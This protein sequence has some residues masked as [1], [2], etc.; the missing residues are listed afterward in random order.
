MWGML[1]SGRWAHGL[2]VLVAIAPAAE[3]Q[4]CSALVPGDVI[5]NEILFDR[6]NPS[7][8]YVELYNRSACPVDL[9]R[10]TLSDSR[11]THE[12]ISEIELLLEP[13]GFTVLASDAAGFEMV[14][15]DVSVVVPGRWPALN[16]G[17]DA[18]VLSDG[19]AVLDS[20]RY[21]GSWGT[22]GR[23]L[24]R[25]APSASATSAASWGPS[26]DPAGGTPG[27][28]NSLFVKDEEPPRLIFAEQ[29]AERE[30][31][32]RFSEP[33]DLARLAATQFRAGAQSPDHLEP[34]LSADEIRLGFASPITAQTL[35]VRDLTDVSGN[36]SQPQEM[37]IAGLPK[38]GDLILNEIMYDPRTGAN[39]Q[40]EYIEVL[41]ASGRR[42][43]I[44]GLQVAEDL[45]GGAV[46]RTP[47][48]NE[49]VALCTGCY[50]VVHDANE[51]HAVGPAPPPAFARFG[52]DAGI[53]ATWFALT[54]VTTRGLSNAGQPIALV[55]RDGVV[56][57][58]VSYAPPWHSLTLRETGETRGTALERRST[59]TGDDPSG[60]TSSVATS[61][62]T[63]GG[64]N[65]VLVESVDG[66]VAAAGLEVVPSPFSPDDDGH[67]DA[68]WIRYRLSSPVALIRIQ[69]FDLAG[70]VR[71]QIERARLSGS[72]G[73]VL[74]DGTDD[75]GNL[76]PTGPYVVVLEG[77]SAEAKNVE[78]HRDL[79][80]VVSP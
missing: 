56:L 14:F 11:L 71:R 28:Q 37:M 34:A 45:Q 60:W 12:S 30:L 54:S 59:G 64:A 73:E 42:L 80:T 47:V 26:N 33:L 38:P 49:R 2:V 69:V 72:E 74:W 22:P 29:D 57:D 21:A 3:A 53:G 35:E 15:A 8:E 61:G 7:F 36:V 77:L 70:R 50:L 48:T 10:L 78:R 66:P 31:Y 76:L 40:P 63:P 24:E 51:L 19:A 5:I 65:S 46:G 52:P 27:R 9:S 23:S 79:V 39:E 43:S 1:D 58:A 62:G 67:E 32:V 75:A 41:N 20:I 68:V 18:V 13:G 16:N 6:T 55:G 17:G 25:R 44:R 4:P